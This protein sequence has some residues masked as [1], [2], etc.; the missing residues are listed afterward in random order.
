M[1]KESGEIP[2]GERVELRLPRTATYEE[3]SRAATAAGAAGVCL[4]SPYHH[5]YV[6]SESELQQAQGEG[7]P[8]N[9]GVRLSIVGTNR[10]P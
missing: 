4:T 5:W 10:V 7:I 1:K 2:R 6:G 3:A 8:E 9:N